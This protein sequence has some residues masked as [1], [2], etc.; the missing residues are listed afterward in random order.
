MGDRRERFPLFPL[1]LV[2]LPGEVV[3]LHIF[4]ERYKVMIGECLEQ[5]REFGIL[6]LSE[7]GLRD[8]GCTATITRLLERME[9]GRM[10]ILVEGA[11]PFRLVRRIEDLPYPAGDVEL[12]D[13]DED[14][15]DP[16][17]S[18]E[19]RKRYADLV[20]RVTDER[21]ADADLE[22][23]DAYRMAA[24]VD[25]SP[26]AKQSLLELRSERERLRM[27]AGLLESTMRRLDH[28]ERMAE[29]AKTNG[30]LRHS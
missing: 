17:A 1:G 22:G 27:V 18:A 19:A 30:R 13:G 5:D 10:N 15:E 8:V 28:A 21:P 29:V 6:W 26:A 9:D 11:C 2:L 12:L 7:E 25:F 3:P 24:T 23:L 4:E 14:P 16:E 20:T